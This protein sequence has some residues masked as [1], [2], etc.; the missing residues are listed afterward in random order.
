MMGRECHSQWSLS[1]HTAD[2]RPGGVGQVEGEG[3]EGASHDS[4]DG[5][6]EQAGAALVR[7][8]VWPMGGGVGGSGG[9]VVAGAATA[10]P[11]LLLLL[12]LARWRQRRRQ[13]LK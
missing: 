11:L 4:G 12:L 2:G 10:P 7:Q 9:V 6:R 1:R 13:L 3:A 5:R 8:S